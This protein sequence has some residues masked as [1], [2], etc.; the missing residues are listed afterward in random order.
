MGKA[1]KTVAGVLGAGAL[2]IG[3]GGLGIGLAGVITGAGAP[4]GGLL[5]AQLFGLSAGTFLG[6]GA[7]GLSIGFQPKVPSLEAASTLARDVSSFAMPAP[8]QKVNPSWL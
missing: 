1:V 3:T 8:A 4:I 6:L 5:G 2:I 7:L